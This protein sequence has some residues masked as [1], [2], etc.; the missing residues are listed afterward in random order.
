MNMISRISSAIFI[1]ICLNLQAQIVKTDEGVI[2]KNIDGNTSALQI[3]VLS[4]NI[5]RVTAYHTQ[6]ITSDNN[7]ILSNFNKKK[8]FSLVVDNDKITI[9]TAA[10]KVFVNLKNG[11]VLFNDKDIRP[12]LSEG[13]RIYK[14]YKEVVENSWTT[15]Q[16]FKW[17]MD[18]ILYG[19]NAN[20]N[21]PQNLKGGKVELDTQKSDG[22]S[23][24]ILSSKGYGI[25]WNSKSVSYVYNDHDISYIWSEQ[26]K[27]IDYYFLYG[28][29]SEDIAISYCKITGKTI[30][31]PKLAQL[32]F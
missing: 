15:Q 31:M 22:I 1:F 30:T 3:M 13:E 24:L 26:A 9:K 6:V 2:L 20:K 18:E 27:Q 16:E 11:K 21:I 19:I 10:L 17:A 8:P 32:T 14:P 25:L 28:P 7:C 5:I 23:P 29:S 12:L 4:D